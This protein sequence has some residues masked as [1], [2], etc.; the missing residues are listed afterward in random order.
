MSPVAVLKNETEKKLIWQSILGS[1]YEDDYNRLHCTQMVG[2]FQILFVKKVHSDFVL[3]LRSENFPVAIQGIIGTKGALGVRFSLYSSSF[4]FITL[5]LDA[6]QKAVEKRTQHFEHILQRMKFQSDDLTPYSHDFVYVFGDLNYRI[7]NLSFEEALSLIHDRE[8]DKLTVNDQLL[9]EK[10]ESVLLS[11]LK[12]DEIT[13]MP[14]YKF[15]KGTSVYNVKKK[16]IPSFCDRILYRGN[17]TT[18]GYNSFLDYKSSDHKPVSMASLIYVNH[19]KKEIRSRDFIEEVAPNFFFRPTKHWKLTDIVHGTILYTGSVTTCN[20]CTLYDERYFF[21]ACSKI[22]VAEHIANVKNEISILTTSESDCHPKLHKVFVDE[23]KI[24]YLYDLLYED[25]WT[26]LK[27][28]VKFNEPETKFLLANVVIILEDLHSRGIVHRDLR[29]ENLLFDASGYL[30]IIDF[31]VSKHLKGRT[32]TRVGT[33]EY[34]SPEMILN[35]GYGFSVD[36]WSLGILAYE[37][38]CGFPPFRKKDF[39]H[40][41]EVLKSN[42]VFPSFVSKCARDLITKLLNKNHLFRLGCLKEGTEDIK[43]HA[44]FKYWDWDGTKQRNVPSFYDPERRRNESG[45]KNMEPMQLKNIFHDFDQFVN[46]LY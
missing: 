46:K 6:H 28:R 3:N 4:C 37:L 29:S 41:E 15:E 43:N 36:F 33:V 38:L 30:K 9:S 17:I 34:I 21:K 18:L 5:H 23:E 20:I 13:F 19:T 22:G 26:V 32:Y 44:F 16:R 8:L 24:Y 25:L 40:L 39:E 31:K 10:K 27:K 14:T 1:I 2:L 12:E 42:V 11:S 7:D 35:T 45:P